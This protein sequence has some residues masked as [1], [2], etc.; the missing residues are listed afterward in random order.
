MHAAT[1]GQHARISARIHT[2]NVARRRHLSSHTE[3]IRFTPRI[4]HVPRSRT[5]PP[6]PPLSPNPIMQFLRVR[7]KRRRVYHV[8]LYLLFTCYRVLLSGTA[9]PRARLLGCAWLIPLSTSR[10]WDRSILS[11]IYYVY[12]ITTSYV[13][14][15]TYLPSTFSVYGS[16]GLVNLAPLLPSAMSSSPQLTYWDLV[17]GNSVVLPFRSNT[18][19]SPPTI[20]SMIP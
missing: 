3:I 18:A 13:L 14:R 8:T 6:L 15:T 20:W 9:S 12:V 10:D 5:V 2:H 4:P 1:D 11:I 16:S 19:S 7:R 17:F